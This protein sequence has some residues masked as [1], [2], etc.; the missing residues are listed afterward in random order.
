MHHELSD[1]REFF[2]INDTV[3]INYKIIDT[4]ETGTVARRIEE[5]QDTSGASEKAQLRILNNNLQQLIDR[6]NQTDRDIARALRLLDEKLSLVTARM[7]RKF[8][9]ISPEE[10]TKVNLSGGGIAFMV[11]TPI[12]A[13]NSMEVFLQL[14]PEGNT[15]HTLARVVS[16]DPPSASDASNRYLLRLAFTHMDEEDRNMLVR[17]TLKRQAQALR[18][19]ELDSV[20]S[21]REL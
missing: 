12:D 10:L 1:K 8:H 6:L 5:A 2:R 3:V 4:S 17:H 19:G 18:N 9:P 15:I 21:L 7:Q 14:L 16:C 20:M 11:D 13:R